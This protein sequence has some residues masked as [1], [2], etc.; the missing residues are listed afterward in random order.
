MH[1]DLALHT[2]PD[3]ELLRR[4]HELT[5]HSR[6]TL[7]DLIAHIGEVDRRRLYARSAS[8]SMFRYCIHVLHLS[9]PEACLRIVAARAA[10]KHP[11]LLAM[12]A[13]W[14]HYGTTVFFEMI[15]A[16]FAACF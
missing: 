14:F 8:P 4:L 2:V 10:R 3:D 5:A 12:L 1:F 11:V 6:S 16:G 7:A 9:E 13:L 15:A